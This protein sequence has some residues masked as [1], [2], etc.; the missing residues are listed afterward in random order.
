ME[1]NNGVP[2]RK[3]IWN[4]VLGLLFFFYGCYRLYVLSENDF[5]ENLLG[6]F[7]AIAFVAFGLYD[8]WKY[9]KGL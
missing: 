8:L 1:N 6:L 3:N 4:L 9:K 7:L 5:Q 2:K